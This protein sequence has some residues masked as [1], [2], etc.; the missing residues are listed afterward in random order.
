MTH[1]SQKNINLKK[2]TNAA[3]TTII[4]NYIDVLLPSTSGRTWLQRPRKGDR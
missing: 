1:K 4:D 2:V 3:V